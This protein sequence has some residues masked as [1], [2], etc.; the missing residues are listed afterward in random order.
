MA[1]RRSGLADE[2]A[3]VAALVSMHDDRRRQADAVDKSAY[4]RIL[5]HFERRG[6]RLRGERIATAEFLERVFREADSLP[7]PCPQQ[8]LEIF[9]P[10]GGKAAGRFRLANPTGDAVRVELVVGE[11]LEGGLVPSIEFA[12]DQVELPPEG[13]TYVRAAVAL[14]G[15]T[16]PKTMT[17]PIECRARTSRSRLWLVVHGIG[18]DGRGVRPMRGGNNP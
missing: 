7:S 15:W 12:P 16:S 3:I 6:E 11:P 13:V 17:I 5:E 18:D 14:D 10:I 1:Q 9:G 2:D 4:E 8:E